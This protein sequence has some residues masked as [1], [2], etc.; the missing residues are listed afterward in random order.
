MAERYPGAVVAGVEVLTRSEVT[1]AHARLRITYE[2][3]GGAPSSVF[4]KMLPDNERRSAVAA[5]RMGTREVRFY[6]D[7]APALKLR[8]PQIVVAH[9]DPADESFVLVMEDLAEAGCVVSDGTWGVSVDAAATAITDLAELHARYENPTR[10]LSEASW[11]QEP[12]FGSTYGST[13]LQTALDCHRDRISVA[14]ASIADLYIR[15][16]KPLFDLW[17]AGPKTVIHGDAHIGNLFV[18]NGAVGF[19]DWGLIT[20]NTPIRDVS[21]FLNMALDITVRRSSEAALIS[22][23]LDARR[24]LGASPISFN[25]AWLGHRIHSA[26]CVVACCQIVAFPEGISLGRQAFSEAF[27]ARA[28]AAIAD[29]ESVAA[30]TQA[31]AV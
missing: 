17:T 10:R 9:A 2:H 22:Q 20:V 1:N 6:N 15:Q 26:Y 5:T 13:M 23:Y 30:I 14:F 16:G 8:V 27:L 7:L 4:C 3:S 31:L 29:L 28:E 11:I 24:A 12:K 18:D 25:E 21:Y 19:L